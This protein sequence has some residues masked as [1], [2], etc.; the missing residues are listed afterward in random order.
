MLDE[1]C[2]LA[3]RGSGGGVRGRG[4][5]PPV[6]NKKKI[7]GFLSNTRPD[8]LKIHKATKP[9]FN[10]GPSSARQRNAIKTLSRLQS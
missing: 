8:S 1:K 4:S 9:T 2:S 6:K 3:M 5:G 7:I 10:V